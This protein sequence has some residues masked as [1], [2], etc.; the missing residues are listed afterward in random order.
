MS[1]NGLR[2][3]TT[4]RESLRAQAFR[5]YGKTCNY[6][7]DV[8]LEV[9]HVIELAAGGENKAGAMGMADGFTFLRNNLLPTHTNGTDV[10]F[11]VRTTVSVEGQATLV[12]EG[13]TTTTG[14]VTKGTTFTIATVNMVHPQTKQDL[15]V[16][17]KFVVT[18][19]AT[20]DG[21]GYATLSISP[22]LYT[23]ASNGLQNISAFPADGDTCTVL[24]GVAS[25]GYTQSLTY[26]PSAF[27]FISTGLY[28]PR[29][30]EMSGKATENGITVNMVSDF[31]VLTRKEILRFDVLY[32]FS[33][34]TSRMGLQNHCI[35]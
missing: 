2:G 9:D 4:K 1:S 5:M 28:Q 6:C 11:E 10:S 18:A 13:L 16:L 20:A 35:I 17:Q 21:S 22:A 15:G 24:T 3:N 27:R 23:S 33:A 31:D 12:V 34:D 30:T 25:T 26:H 19:D 32:G 7:G 8:G 14:T 29:N